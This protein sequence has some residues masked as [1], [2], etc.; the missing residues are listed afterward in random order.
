MAIDLCCFDFSGV[1]CKSLLTDPQNC[2]GC[3]VQCPSNQ[4]CTNGACS[5]DVAPCGIG[6]RNLYCDLA[7]EGAASGVCC[8]GSGC[9]NL[10]V[11]PQNCGACNSPCLT[12]FSCVSGQ[13]AV[14]TCTSATQ[15][16]TCLVAGAPTGECCGTTCASI[17]S[18]PAN[19]GACGTTCVGGETCNGGGCGFDSCAGEQG[20][21]CHLDAGSVIFGGQ[22][23]SNACLDTGTDPL[24]CGGCNL[25]CPGNATCSG[26]HCS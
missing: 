26:G 24:N 4:S 18:D 20:N 21:P 13:C 10:Q 1:V 5:G 12:G 17:G 11:D 6:S 23:C 7:G 9:T 22:C 16:Q 15:Q 8:P 3:G 2:G 25:P 19:C 14:A